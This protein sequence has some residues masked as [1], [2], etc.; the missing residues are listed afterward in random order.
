MLSSSLAPGHATWGRVARRHQRACYCSPALAVTHT[1]PELCRGPGSG[2][3]GCCCSRIGSPSQA[4]ATCA[5]VRHGVRQDTKGCIACLAPAWP[6]DCPALGPATAVLLAHCPTLAVG[7]CRAGP[8]T[9][10]AM[11]WLPWLVRS[12][13]CNGTP[14][15]GQG[16]RGSDHLTR[17]ALVPWCQHRAWV[18][19]QVHEH[20]LE[21][22]QGVGVAEIG[23]RVVAY[24]GGQR[25]AVSTVRG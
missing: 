25:S 2:A 3:H 20:T 8:A 14:S 22:F 5:V 6:R 1:L 16:C 19:L 7:N 13:C 12:S 24:T 18:A 21:V 4:V 23:T 17:L 9:I 15:S 10:A 11:S